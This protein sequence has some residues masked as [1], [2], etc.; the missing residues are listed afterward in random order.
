MARNY[1]RDSKGRF[2]G[3]GGGGGSK[4]KGGGTSTRAKNTA[5]AGELQA[6][7]T[8]AI[9]SR[10]KAKGFS[11][12]KGAQQRAGGLRGNVVTGLK[13]GKST[14]GAGT[15]SGLKA[16]AAQ[17]GKSRSRAASK[18][19]SKMSKAPASAAKTRF[20]ELSSAAR[21]SSP[22]RSAAENRAAAG[23]KRS[24]NAMIKKRGRK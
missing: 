15:R 14:A 16:N 22:F 18:G 20:K 10:V 1:K 9:G 2:S 11:G 6:K 3:T 23:A 7:G 24:L 12:Q 4:N 17:V 13:G 5:R 21:K 19:A 8:T